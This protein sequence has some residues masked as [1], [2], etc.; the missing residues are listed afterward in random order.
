MSSFVLFMPCHGVGN[1]EPLISFNYHSQTENVDL[2]RNNIVT[3]PI[4]HS[5][6]ELIMAIKSTAY[7]GRRLVL[8]CLISQGPI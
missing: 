6:F 8:L 3:L 4:I 7:T 5:Q 1:H 2:F